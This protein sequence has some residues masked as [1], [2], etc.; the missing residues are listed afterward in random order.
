VSDYDVLR[1]TR[2]SDN[3]V[4]LTI[5]QDGVAL[6]LTGM[7]VSWAAKSAH[8]DTAFAL[9]PYNAT[10]TLPLEGKCRVDIPDADS[11]ALTKSA[12]LWD[13]K[14]TAGADEVAV[15]RGVLLILS[16]VQP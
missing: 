11:Q 1:I 12:Y 16:A 10:L 14:V 6:D 2:G 13:A 8:S 4:L 5:T 3:D 9:G 7:T 15:A